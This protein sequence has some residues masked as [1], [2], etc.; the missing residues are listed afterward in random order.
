MTIFANIID[1][2]E[3]TT[4][5]TFDVVNPSTGAVVGQAVS[6]DAAALDRAVAAARRAHPGWAA[7]P[8]ADRQDACNRIAALIE[9]NADELAR[10][11]SQEQG[12][13][14][15]GVGARF[16]IGGAQAWTAYT[17]SLTLEPEILQDTTKAG[18]NCTAC[19]SASWA[20][21]RRGTGR[22]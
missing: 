20:R 21:S 5:A 3:D 1:G 18:S 7:T 11:L 9:A 10:L 13:P 19:P 2:A 17:A 8:W 22:C 6:A 12:K 15:N 14:L 16:E 4:G